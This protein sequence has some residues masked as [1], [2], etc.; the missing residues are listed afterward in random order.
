VRRAP[1]WISLAGVGLELAV[2]AFLSRVVYT[3]DGARP[4]RSSSASLRV[5]VDD[6]DRAAQGPAKSQDDTPVN[7]LE[8]I[9]EANDESAKYYRA[10]DD[11]GV[12]IFAA[13]LSD[14]RVRLADNAQHRFA[15]MV[16]NGHADLLEIA[17]NV[18]SELF[19]RV[20]PAGQMQFELRG[21]PYDTH[22]LTCEPFSDL[23]RAQDDK[24]IK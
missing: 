7:P 9:T 18:W 19:L 22:V 6:V 2:L 3:R 12:E 1:G 13:L 15:G 4:T 11:R 20:T 14:G 5:S 23:R 10:A 21:G 16:E 17:N 24:V 8:F